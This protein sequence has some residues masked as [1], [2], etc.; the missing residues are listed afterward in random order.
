VSNFLL[1][2]SAYAE[3][4]ITPTFWPD[5]GKAEFYKALRSFEQRERRYG[6]LR[7]VEDYLSEDEA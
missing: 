4:Y 7:D 2:Q 5:F 1:W 6:G 3:F